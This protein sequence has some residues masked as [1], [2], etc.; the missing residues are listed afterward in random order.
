MTKHKLIAAIG[1]LPQ[2][3]AVLERGVEI[4]NASQ[5]DLHLVHV[6]D[7]PGTKADLDDI[8]T[9]P[10]QEAFA[11]RDKLKAALGTLG[12]DLTTVK[13]HMA[14]GLH[15]ISLIDVC[16]DVLPDLIVMRA[17]QKP[18]MAEKLLGSTTERVIAAAQAP[19]LVVKQPVENRYRSVVLATN[20]TDD[21]SDMAHFVF[22]H[23]PD[24][25][26]HVV[27]S[28]QI[29]PQLKEAMLRVGT[30][31]VDLTAHRRKLVKEA[32]DHLRELTAE[33]AQPVTSQVFKG[34]P[35][36][37][38]T[39]LCRTPDVDLMALGQG[40]ASLI[41]RAFIGSVSRRLLR[42][43]ACDVLILCRK[44]TT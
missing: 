42:D 13:M 18:K 19:V 4:S 23:L 34:E 1:Q 7:L 32:E 36:H 30:R 39:R 22:K 35:V 21:A 12:A 20:G 15:A 24:V 28:V 26:L 16:K 37:T 5:A 17:H 10:G 31:A 8:S 29:P 2:D 40:K 27:Q 6:L 11:M 38:L 14:L 9:L 33:F 3:M 25:K 43:A 41:R 44:R